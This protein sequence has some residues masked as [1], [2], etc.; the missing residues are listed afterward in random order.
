[1]DRFVDLNGALMPADKPVITLDNRA[2]HYGDG[3][4]ES[5]RV[6]RGRPCFMDAH[7]ARLVEC[8]ALLR[9]DLPA[10]FDR[11][12]AEH[13]IVRLSERNGVLSG[14]CR[15]TIYRDA[16]GFYRPT[17][18]RGGYAI[19]VVPVDQE[20]YTLNER[21]LTVDIYPEMR[22][23]VN[24]LAVHKTL[25]CQYYVL[26]SLWCEARGLDDC[27][28]QNDRGNII[29]S[30]TG[31]LFIVSN[32]VL[33]TPSLADGCLGGIMRMQIINLALANGIK[34]YECS[35][36]P[37]N[38][39]AADELFFTNASKGPQWVST[40]RT[41]RYTHRTSKA[42]VELLVRSLLS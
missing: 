27:L 18:H 19:E 17:S 38:L 9:I 6:L 35:L 1:M 29:E 13:A 31:N 23:P 4:F 12:G 16:G 40:Y 25:N 42:L 39:L 24:A 11:D 5:I 10:G 7:W 41:K 34:V 32:G 2:F 15:L 36:N 26:A 37:Q 8:C 30:S 14:R 22:K 20:T 21:G 3:L 28:L 33:Y